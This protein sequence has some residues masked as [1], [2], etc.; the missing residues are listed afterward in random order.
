MINIF[1]IL[2]ITLLLASYLGYWRP[3]DMGN[4]YLSSPMMIAHRGI[5][6]NSPENTIAAYQE[7]VSHGFTA[8]ELDV[9]STKDGVLICSHNHDLE[10]ETDSTGWVNELLM[11]DI[12]QVKTGLFSHPDNQQDIPTLSAV[13]KATPSHIR[14]NIEIKFDGVFDFSTAA[15]LASMI[16]TGGISHPVLISSFN[17]FIVLYVRWMI[18]SVR[19]GYLVETPDMMKWIHVVHPDC[20]HPQADLLTSDVLEMC[21]EK[22]LPLNVWTVNSCPAIKYCKQSN[23]Q[24][25]ITDNPSALSI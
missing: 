9:I 23:F 2:L 16:K 7:A 17:P 12:E 1:L 24:A 10:R 4:Y 20:F 5:K 18:P 19:T 6:I 3:R 8:I 11:V 22:N 15:A 21:R 25:V 14:L 13:I